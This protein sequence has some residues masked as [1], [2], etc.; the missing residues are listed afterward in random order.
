MLAQITKEQG[1]G[2]ASA[3]YQNMGPETNSKNELL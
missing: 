3:K 1:D 2:N